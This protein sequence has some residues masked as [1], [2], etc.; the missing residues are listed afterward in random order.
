MGRGQWIC[1]LPKGDE[2]FSPEKVA[3][4]GV[5]GGGRGL[6]TQSSYGT[7]PLVLRGCQ[8]IRV[9]CDTQPSIYTRG[10]LGDWS[11]FF[12]FIFAQKIFSYPK[13]M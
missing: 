12:S 13:I 6:G 9:L 3:S 8:N 7:P 4:G 11:L 10:P 1:A 2:G 5:G